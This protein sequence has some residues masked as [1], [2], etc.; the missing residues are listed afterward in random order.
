MVGLTA[1][2][3]G[4]AIAG[5]TTILTQPTGTPI[6]VPIAVGYDG[7]AHRVRPT[8]LPRSG[9]AAALAAPGA[10]PSTTAPPT[11]SSATT[12]SA[13]PTTSSTPAKSSSSATPAPDPT[14]PSSKTE[15][16]AP[17]PPP[18]QN[19][20][21]GLAGEVIT[22]VNQERAGKCAPLTVDDRLTTSA[23]RH[24]S[25]MATRKYFSHTTPD[26]VSFDQRI[27]AAGYP[28]PAAENIAKGQRTAA[29]VMAGWMDSS[30]HRAN[31]LNCS[32]KKIGVGVDTNGYLWT[33]N[34]GF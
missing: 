6:E 1:L 12:S 27:R 14:T 33:Q 8:D 4:A 24:S 16:P 19:P 7:A 17:P 11:T 21:P 9:D 26:G 32:Y 20:S 28:S 30:G 15:T 10:T 25:D 22:L 29:Q 23:Q 18:Q 31:I 34:F 13:A 2:V 5:V 3:A